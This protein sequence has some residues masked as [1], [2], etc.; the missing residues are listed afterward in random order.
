MPSVCQNRQQNRAF[1]TQLEET[2]DDSVIVITVMNIEK[3]NELDR[4]N[5][6]VFSHNMKHWK[7][8]SGSQ[9]N[10]QTLKRNISGT[11]RSQIENVVATVRTRVYETT[12]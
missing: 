5:E 11:V 9:F 4:G 10:M 12:L 1:P 3:T 6:E 7:V 8:H 2:A